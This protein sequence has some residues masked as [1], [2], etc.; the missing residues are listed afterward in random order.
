MLKKI[1]I[2]IRNRIVNVWEFQPLE[3]FKGHLIGKMK[4]IK[5][6]IHLRA[7]G[8][9]FVT[10]WHILTESSTV[11]YIVTFR[12]KHLFVSNFRRIFSTKIRIAILSTSGTCRLFEFSV[13]MLPLMHQIFLLEEIN[14][15]LHGTP[16]NHARVLPFAKVLQN[17]VGFWR[18]LRVSCPCAG[19]DF[20]ASFSNMY[21]QH[22]P[23]SLP[24]C[25]QF[26]LK[27]S[28]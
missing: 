12:G 26:F 16:F 6:I 18:V 5:H 10:F 3:G 25:Q 20:L 28:R 8:F 15:V 23:L 1:T 13:F 19:F 2:Q 14:P 7:S 11:L 4:I 24:V 21:L 27:F 9:G 22:C 17:T